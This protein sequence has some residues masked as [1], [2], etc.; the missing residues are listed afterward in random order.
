MVCSIIFPLTQMHRCIPSEQGDDNLLLLPC[1]LS[2]T[3]IACLFGLIVLSPFVARFQLI[4]SDLRSAKGLP[5][6]FFTIEKVKDIFRRYLA[7]KARQEVNS[8]LLLK[9]NQYNK[10]DVLSYLK[11]SHLNIAYV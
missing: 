3:Y 8:V 5:D 6:E 1:V 10:E 11:E 4:R 7:V 9:M 2:S